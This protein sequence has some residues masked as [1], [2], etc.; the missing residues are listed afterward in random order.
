[1]EK[2]AVQTRLLF[3]CLGNICRSPAAENIFR[4]IAAKHKLK[5][6]VDSAGTSSWH[7]GEL[8]DHRMRNS[9]NKR[10]FKGLGCSRP[11][12]PKK[13]FDQFDLIIAMDDFNYIDLIQS[14]R[15]EDDKAK[16]HRMKDF[17][18]ASSA[19]EIP[20]PY[21]GGP[22][23]FDHVIDLLVDASEGLVNHLKSNPK[24]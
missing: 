11:F 9:L 2:K 8:P 17:F 13:D 3:V 20:D 5:V 18:L 7:E 24:H 15:N 21:Y 6:E 10:G 23:G 19:N 12:N 16:I 1:M 22:T 14:A 4:E